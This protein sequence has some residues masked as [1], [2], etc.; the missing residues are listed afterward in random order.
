MEELMESATYREIFESGEEHGKEKTHKEDI[1]KIIKNR[2]KAP[3]ESI[4][5]KL[6]PVKNLKDLDSLFDSALSSNSLQDFENI[7]NNAL[8]QSS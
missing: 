6:K 7:L 8:K 1:L 5:E 2:F 3:L 4:E